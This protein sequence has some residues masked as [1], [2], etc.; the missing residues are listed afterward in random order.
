[1]NDGMLSQEEINALLA[2]R[3]DDQ[4]EVNE[5]A[6]GE[7]DEEK[8][9]EVSKYLSSIEVDTLGE[10]GNISFGSSATTLSTLLNEKVDITTPKISILRKSNLCKEFPFDHVKIQVNYVQGFSGEN[11]RSEERRVGKECRTRL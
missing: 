4:G 7:S 5:G 6:S 11:L 8:E 9:I 1:M 3:Q 2:V 10:I